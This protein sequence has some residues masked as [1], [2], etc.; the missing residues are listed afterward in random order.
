MFGYKYKAF[1]NIL[2]N[3][4]VSASFILKGRDFQILEAVNGKEL[5][6]WSCGTAWGTS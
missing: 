1:I 5:I 4:I 3:E 2:N 6:K